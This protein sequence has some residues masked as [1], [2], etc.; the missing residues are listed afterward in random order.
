[1][2]RWSV[3]AKSTGI[4]PVTFAARTRLGL[5]AHSVCTFLCRAMSALKAL[6]CIFALL[7]RT[8][9][10]WAIQHVA[11]TTVRT[12]SQPAVHD[13]ARCTVS[14]QNTVQ[15]ATVASV[16]QTGVRQGIERAP[17]LHIGSWRRG[18]RCRARRCSSCGNGW[19]NSVSRR[20]THPCHSRLLHNRLRAQGTAL[21]S[22]SSTETCAKESPRQVIARF[23]QSLAAAART[24]RS[25]ALPLVASSLVE[26]HS[27]AQRQLRASL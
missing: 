10:P 6:Q 21:M 12:H 25:F 20:R 19:R 5:M 3:L 9:S 27:L 26:Q 17:C 7:S 24:T 23:V 14:W 16:A 15:R 1:M 2:R 18:T 4:M 22:R 13:F 11:L 8:E